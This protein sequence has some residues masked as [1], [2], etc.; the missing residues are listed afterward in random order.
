MEDMEGGG[1]VFAVSYEGPILLAA[2]CGGDGT[3]GWAL[4]DPPPAGQAIRCWMGKVD[5]VRA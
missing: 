3:P 4:D 5:G 1:P 2:R